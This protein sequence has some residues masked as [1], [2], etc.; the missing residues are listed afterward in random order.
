MQQTSVILVVDD[1]PGILKLVRMQLSEDGFRVLTAGSGEESLQVI[2]EQRPD[3]ILLDVML[4]GMSGYEVMRA[5]RERSATPI[6]MLTA[7]AN[8]VDK[9]LG[10]E[11]GADDYVVKPFSPEELSARVRAVLRRIRRS[12]HA[13][14]PILNVRDLEIDLERRVVTRSGEVLSLTRTEWNLL[15]AL[16][17][18]SGKVMLSAEILSRVWGPEYRD[19]VQYL[20][21]WVSRL[22]RK[23]EPDRP[24]ES[25]IRTFPGMGYM[26]EAPPEAVAAS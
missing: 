12:A 3:L 18:N 26:L 10:L 17:E 24:D 4:P 14:E 22:R 15:Q 5:V 16:A 9:V 13:G 25:V 7:R 19:D 21:V 2:E 8:D 1:D 11:M 20:R 23:L 6:V